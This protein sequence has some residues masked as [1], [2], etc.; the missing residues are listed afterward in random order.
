MIAA[1]LVQGAF[2]ERAIEMLRDYLGPVVCRVIDERGTS[3]GGDI[4]ELFIRPGWVAVEKLGGGMEPI[5][6]AVGTVRILEVLKLL[7]PYAGVKVGPDEPLVELTL[8][9]GHA[10]F[11]GLYLG[12]GGFESFITIRFHRVKSLTLAEYVISGGLKRETA[13]II[14]ICL[15]DP[16]AGW[17]IVGPTGSGKTT[18]LRALCGEIIETYGMQEHLVTIEDTRELWLDGPYITAFEAQGGLTYRGAVRSS[19]R[20]K[21]TRIIVGEARGGEAYDA[22]KGGATGHGLYMTIHA[23]TVA[24]GFRNLEARM[25]EGSENGFV[26]RE[27]IQDAFQYAV[28]MQRRGGRFVVGEAVRFRG[29]QGDRAIFEAIERM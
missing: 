1:T 7:A 13:E 17:L 21:P 15:R 4:T 23:P 11:A 25:R 27:M 16:Q 6:D 20:H 28:S 22:V 10:R 2:D 3:D 9:F 8:P 29:F 14:R 18:F 19:L 24:A 12:V 5:P 26:D